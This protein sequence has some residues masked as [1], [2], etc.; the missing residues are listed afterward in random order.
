MSK[1]HPMLS[2]SAILNARERE[3]VF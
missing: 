1:K 2:F 3:F